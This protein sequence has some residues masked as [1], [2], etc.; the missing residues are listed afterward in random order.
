MKSEAVPLKI[1]EFVEQVKEPLQIVVMGICARYN[2]IPPP[3]MLPALA[4]AMGAVMSEASVTTDIAETLK[5]RAAIED[6][7]KNILKKHA[8]PLRLVD[9]ANLK[10]S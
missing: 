2:N 7:F 4:I 1:D 9:T 5:M 6:A 10:A 3:I 8:S